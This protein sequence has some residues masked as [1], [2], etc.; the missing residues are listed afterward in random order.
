[1]MILILQLD[2]LSCWMYIQKKKSLSKK[3]IL[4]KHESRCAESLFDRDFGVVCLKLKLQS[5][6]ID[7]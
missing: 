3:I 4:Q 6:R 2:F 5:G 1:M 7:L